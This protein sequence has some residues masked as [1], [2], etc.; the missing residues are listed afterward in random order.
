MDGACISNS[1]DSRHRSFFRIS[2]YL[3][4]LY[5]FFFFNTVGLPSPLEYTTILSPF[6][7][8]WLVKNRYKF[9]ATRFLLFSLPFVVIHLSQGVNYRTYVV[10][11]LYIMSIYF[12]VYAFYVAVVNCR[13][14]GKMLEHII[15][16]NFI[17][18]CFA[19]IIINSEFSELLWWSVPIGSNLGIVKRLKL[20][21]YEASYYST[22]LVPLFFYSYYKVILYKNNKNMLLF[23]ITLIPIALSFS[24]GIIS[25]LAISIVLVNLVYIQNIY[26][27]NKR[28]VKIAL[29]AVFMA[30]LL[31]IFKTPFYDRFI[32]VLAGR[33]LSGTG[34]TYFSTI[35]A[36]E[37]A[38]QKNI[39]WGV[40]FGQPKGY[41]DIMVSFMR[42]NYNQGWMNEHLYN[43]IA[44]LLAATGIIGVALK[45]LAELILFFKTKVFN[46][47]FSLSLFICI[48]V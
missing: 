12:V 24:F 35:I 23:I 7:Y 22:L 6:F 19:L 48:F 5:L 3:P 46:N 10:S 47:Y 17:I 26:K 21:T 4:F 11:Y 33:D 13:N 30:I 15:I 2:I 20:F 40:G 31:I 16:V 43:S 32:D 38:R 39:W 28:Y 27:N 41:F 34:R 45:I 1:G 8:L 37:I 25:S 44:D 18:S 36:F 9:V 14:I 29:P 42:A